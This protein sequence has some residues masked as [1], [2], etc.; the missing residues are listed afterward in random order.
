[1]ERER[2]C[3][4]KEEQE[5]FIRDFNE[6]EDWMI[7]YEC[8]LSL[9]TDLEPLL[10]EEKTPDT[11]IEGC[12]AKLW[13]VLSMKEGRVQIRADSEALI[14]KGIVAVIVDLLHDRTPEEI[15]E[16]ALDFMER[17]PI[18]SQVSVDRFHGM[19]KVIEK[20]RTFAKR[21]IRNPGIWG[22]QK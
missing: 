9:T 6:L 8:L 16:S 18:R 19:Q 13:V 12:Q 1:M 17:T 2:R 4:V 11:L 3:S 7:Q 21:Q 20:I 14:V 5:E 15:C 22:L 10:P